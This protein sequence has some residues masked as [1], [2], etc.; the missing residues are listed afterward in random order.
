MLITSPE[1]IR[2]SLQDRLD[3]WMGKQPE[4]TFMERIRLLL[5]SEPLFEN[6][7]FAVRYGHTLGYILD[8]MS[9]VHEP[10]EL[11]FG[12]VLEEIPT[13]EENLF[14]TS[15]YRQWW[16]IP[17]EEKQKQVLWFYSDGW[18]KCRAPWFYSFGH[19]ALDWS[20]L[21]NEGLGSFLNQTQ[22]RLK[23]QDLA[24]DQRDFLTG[25]QLCHEAMDRL[26]G[27]YAAKSRELGLTVE[28]ESLEHIQT[29]PARNFREALQLIWLIVLPLAKVAGCGVLNLDR[30]DQYLHPYYEADLASGRLSQQE[31]L[32]LIEEFYYKNNAIMIPADHMSQETS[33]VKSVLEVTYDDPNY[34]TLGGLKADGSSGVNEVSR[35]MIQATSRLKLRNPFIVVRWHEGIDNGFWLDVVSAMRDN[36]TVVIYNDQ[37]MIPALKRYGA[38]EP[39]VYDY[40][41]FGCNDPVIGANEGGLRQ[42]WFNLARPLDLALHEGQCLFTSCSVNAAN[43][44]PQECQYSLRDRMIGLMLGEYKG[45]TTK[46]LSEVSSMEEFIDL[47]RQQTD[48]LLADYRKGFEAD[49]AIERVVNRGRLRIEDCFLKGTIEE[50]QTWNDGGTKYHKIVTQGTGLATVADSLAAIEQLVFV[51]KAMSLSE[52]GEVLAA[53]FAGHERLAD[54]LARQ[55]PKFGNDLDSVDRYARIATDIFCDAIEKINGPDYQYQLWPTLSSDRDF[56]TMGLD[57]AATPDGRRAGQPLSENQS[58]AT[59]CDRNGLTALLNSLAKVPFDRITGGPLNM[60]IHPSAC[61]GPEGLQILADL[62]ATYFAQGGMQLQINVVDSA[63]L[64]EAQLHPEHYRGLC[65]RVTGYSAYFVQM[66][67][68]AQDELINRTEQGA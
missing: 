62:F 57:V 66:G 16:D 39:E 9:V 12:N 15:I 2:K 33:A 53:D 48:F 25:V 64:R 52:L 22:E 40:G 17:D 36:A 20:R 43:K 18:L 51:E 31:A 28:A 68:K 26:I 65:V 50:A 54:R 19:L 59:G 46:K 14:Y 1:P 44:E 45:C 35:L 11:L 67:R 56:T 34:L 42:L 37:T 10:G 23:D 32:D 47:Y 6:E 7:P 61:G 58:P 4:A 49:R 30:M 63:Q 55:Y 41:F 27:R 5:E 29:G 60:R 38:E 13:L 21:I 24:A 8:R 3:Y